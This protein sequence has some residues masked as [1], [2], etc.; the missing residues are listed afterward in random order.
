MERLYPVT[1][2]MMLVVDSV[3]TIQGTVFDMHDEDEIICK[4]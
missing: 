4:A 1:K 3:N 2:C